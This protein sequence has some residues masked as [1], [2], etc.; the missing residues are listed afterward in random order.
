[1]YVNK[2]CTQVQVKKL[3]PREAA[4]LLD[5]QKPFVLDVRP[6]EFGLNQSYIRGAEHCPLMNLMDRVNDFPR[7]RP[8]IITDW[9]MKQA[10]IA[11]IYLI[12]N[13][14]HVLG[15]LKGGME[16]WLTENRPVEEREFP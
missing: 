16:R 15:V 11:A 5:T 14:Y 10:P 1:M 9:T 3:S 6:I 12:K 8:L 13:N 2:T 7:D 4:A